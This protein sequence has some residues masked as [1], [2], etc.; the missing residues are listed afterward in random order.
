MAASAVDMMKDTDIASDADERSE[1]DVMEKIAKD[2]E[3]HDKILAKLLERLKYSEDRMSNFYPRWAANEL[4]LQAWINHPKNEQA[5]KEQNE[6]GEVPSA[7]RIVIPF[8]FAA[9]STLVTYL[10]HAFSSRTPMFQLGSYKDSTVQSARRMETVLQY[11][12]DYSKLVKEMWRYFSDWCTYGVAVFRTTWDV[13]E[14]M[15]TTRRRVYDDDADIENPDVAGEVQASRD[16]EVIYEGNMTTTVDPYG[17]FPDPRVPMHEVSRH[18]EFVFWRHYMCR[19]DLVNMEIDGDFIGVSDV[20][21]KLP[22]NIGDTSNRSLLAR[23]ISTPGRDADDYGEGVGTSTGQPKDTEFMQVDQ[24]TIRMVPDQWDVGES[25]RAEIWQVT[26]LNKDRIVQFQPLDADHGR[27]PVSVSEPYGTGYGFGAISPADMIGPLQDLISWMVNS[28]IE[29]VRT[30][31]NNMLVV[32]PSRIVM[33]D[34][35]EPGPGK[36][37][38]LKQSA[39]GTDIRAIIHQLDI[40]DVTQGHIRDVELVMNL[41]MMILAINEA[42]MGRPEGGDRA[43]AT[44]SRINS[45]AA[46][47]R[48]AALSRIFSAQGITDL[49]EL[50][51]CNTQQ[52]LTEDFALNLLGDEG[53]ELSI[54][55]DDLNGIFTYPVHDGSLPTD[56]TALADI[57]ERIL[58]GVGED[59]ELRATYDFPRIFETAAEIAGAKDIQTM[60]RQQNN[61]ESQMPM[62]I[63]P[64][65]QVAAMVKQGGMSPL[66]SM[67]RN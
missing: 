54:F 25:K 8:G 28:H 21:S 26:I 20:K 17:F 2:K 13:Q 10:M 1:T 47:S 55:S 22:H 59:E 40:K 4:R 32:D 24:G 35:K 42:T 41:G 12:V 11:Q 62:D 16:L 43:T 58:R 33:K 38:R 46:T 39:R 67:G 18:G 7:V 49:T 45:Q 61:A 31:L 66:A 51:V 60:R 36:Y 34:L 65:D 56:K 63:L 23:G 30:H 57:W 44:E 6:S 53:E 29:N 37:I 52:Y 19:L 9:V 27:H 48:L 5:L 50:M 3:L 15:R 14:G 64:D